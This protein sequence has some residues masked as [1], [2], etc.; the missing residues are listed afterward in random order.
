M[1][2]DCGSTHFFS[3]CYDCGEE[4]DNNK[5]QNASPKQHLAVAVI[6]LRR[7]VAELGSPKQSVQAER[8]A[9][10]AKDLLS[11]LYRLG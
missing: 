10:S 4:W 8:L 3:Q 6:A 5:R 1:C 11:R 2:P 9:D 7:A